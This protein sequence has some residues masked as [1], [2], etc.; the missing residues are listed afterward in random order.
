MKPRFPTAVRPSIVTETTRLDRPA[1]SVTDGVSLHGIATI[2]DDVHALLA[3]GGVGNPHVL[4]DGFE[5]RSN[6]AI[7]TACEEITRRRLTASQSAPQAIS[8]IE[9]DDYDD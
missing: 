8:P 3:Q 4:P 6:A 7:R 2:P 9:A 5:L 1:E